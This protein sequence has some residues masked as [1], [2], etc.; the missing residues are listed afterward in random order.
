MILKRIQSAAAQKK[1]WH[2][3]DVITEN[4]TG[5]GVLSKDL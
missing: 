5:D 2:F 1:E 3:E 4:I